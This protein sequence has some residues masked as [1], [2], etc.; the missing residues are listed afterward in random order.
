MILTEGAYRVRSLSLSRAVGDSDVRPYV[1]STPEIASFTSCFD[2]EFIIVS[3]DGLWHG[4]S[5]QD[6][7]DFINKD[8]QSVKGSPKEIEARLNMSK[9]L[10]NE[11][12]RNG[13]SD[14][15]SV[16]IRWLK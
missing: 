5:S 8:L 11:A 9:N 16:I 12:M 14:N 1:I 6:A 2:D 13:E 15:L 4:F 10:I 7:V 3:T